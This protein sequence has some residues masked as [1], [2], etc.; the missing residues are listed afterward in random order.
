MC[1]SVCVCLSHD[2][3]FASPEGLRKLFSGATMASSR[4]ALVTVGQVRECGML[5]VWY[6][7][8]EIY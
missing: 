8:N 6:A 3:V 7:R 4:G 5:G 1:V 2:A